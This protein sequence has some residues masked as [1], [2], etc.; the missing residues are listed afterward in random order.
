MTTPHPQHRPDP[1][2]TDALRAKARTRPGSWMY[3]IDPACDPAGEVPPFAIIGGWQ[4]DHQG[5][6]VR[7]WHNPEYRPSPRA[8][9][10]PAPE[11][12]AEAALQSAATGHGTERDLLRALVDASLAVFAHPQYPGLYVEPGPQGVGVVTG[13][14]SP[15]RMPSDWPGCR[16]LTARQLAQE[17]PGALLRLNPTARPSVTI[18]LDDI[19][20]VA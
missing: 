11:N 7:Y 3:E 9:G 6:P 8:L 5:V 14:T 13:Y 18:P 15:S 17:A 19:V 10:M 2:I 1:P 16:Q 20:R 12:A 4:I